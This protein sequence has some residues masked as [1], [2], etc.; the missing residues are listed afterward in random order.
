MNNGLEEIQIIASWRVAT[1]YNPDYTYTV[2]YKNAQLYFS[3]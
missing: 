3:L 1:L 2:I